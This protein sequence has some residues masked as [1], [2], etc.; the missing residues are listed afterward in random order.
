MA[1]INIRSVFIFVFIATIFVL[2]LLL[3]TADGNGKFRLERYD[4]RTPP[5]PQAN[6]IPS[7][8]SSPPPIFT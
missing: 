6:T 3:V 7:E 8:P 5:T 4:P 1:S 2:Q